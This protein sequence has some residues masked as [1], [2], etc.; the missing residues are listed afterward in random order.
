MK[1]KLCVSIKSLILAFAIS[2]SLASQ[3]F[4]AT[5]ISAAMSGDLGSPING[6]NGKIYIA[7]LTNSRLFAISISTD[8]VATISLP[9]QPQ[10]LGRSLSISKDKTLMAVPLT[11]GNIA[12]VNLSTDQVVATYSL[13]G[14][15]PQSTVL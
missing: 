12:I 6:E 5:V 11:S 15:I 13:G 9:G 14:K 1:V 4:C 3:A 2:I 7:D 10:T 8:A